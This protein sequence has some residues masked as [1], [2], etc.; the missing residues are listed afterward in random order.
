ME[1]VV[2]KGRG[3]GRNTRAVCQRGS[4][5]GEATRRND[6]VVALAELMLAVD[7]VRVRGVGQYVLAPDAVQRLGAMPRA[8]DAARLVELSVAVDAAAAPRDVPR[9]GEVGLLHACLDHLAVL[10]A[11]MPELRVHDRRPEREAVVRAEDFVE[12]VQLEIAHE[13]RRVEQRLARRSHV[14]RGQ[15][16][17]P[18]A[19]AEDRLE[20]EERPGDDDPLASKRQV[21]HLPYEHGGRMGDECLCSKA[22][23]VR[24]A[25][26]HR[27]RRRA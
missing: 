13:R 8:R 15:V 2:G 10:G 24:A 6:Q 20:L 26:T 11:Q 21:A 14:R 19:G 1:S 5:L 18:R 7:P 17:V 12:D 9:V 4:A 22:S 3:E 27:H 23:W 16:G 25:A